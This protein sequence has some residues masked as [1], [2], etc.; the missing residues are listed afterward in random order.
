MF[1][2]IQGQ[3][4]IGQIIKLNDKTAILTTGTIQMN[5][6]TSR[7]IPTEMPK[8]H[9]SSQAFSFISKETRDEIYEKKL[10]FRP[11]IDVRGMNGEEA[12][13]AVTYFV[14]DAILL[15]VARL[16]ILH[17]TGSGYLRQVIR[18]YLHSVPN[19]SDCRDEHVQFGGAGITIV[20][21][22]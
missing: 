18:Q 3:S 9:N 11:E 5:I 16:R 17:G 19:V 22:K 21:L 20:D 2:K 6:A 8:Q 1:V 4:G 14:D 13:H 15:G 10:N 12:L 7:L